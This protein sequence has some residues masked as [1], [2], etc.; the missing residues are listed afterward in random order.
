MKYVYSANF[1]IIFR[2]HLEYSDIH[3]YTHVYTYYMYKM[4]SYSSHTYTFYIMY[5]WIYQY[6]Y[7]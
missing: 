4:Y 1:K 6:M 5:K 7:I 3:M 2:K